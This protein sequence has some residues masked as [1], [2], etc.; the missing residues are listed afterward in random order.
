MNSK[1]YL[2]I[3]IMEGILCWTNLQDGMILRITYKR[4]KNYR[5]REEAI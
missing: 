2:I 1:H 4:R 5:T 3:Q